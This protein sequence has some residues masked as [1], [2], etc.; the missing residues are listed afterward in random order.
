MSPQ[1]A[2][3]G[4]WDTPITAD[5]ITGNST[6]L[7]DIVVDPIT[8]NIYHLELRPS[9][10]GRTV[11]VDTRAKRDIFGPEWNAADGVHEYGGGAA[12]VY[13]GIAYFSNFKDGRIY[14]VSVKDDGAAPEAVTPDNLPY[15]Y[16]NFAIHPKYT[17]LIVAILEDHTH[18]IPSEVV[19]TLCLIDTNTKT[20]SPKFV[21]GN[22]F[23]SHPVFSTDGNYLAWQEWSFPDMPWEGGEL[24]VA[25]VQVDGGKLTLKSEAK[26]AGEKE[27]YSAGYPLWA[28]SETLIFISD[29]SGFSNPW[30]YTVSDGKASPILPRTVEEDFSNCMWSLSMFPFAVIAGGKQ[31]I[32]SS[33]KDGKNFL[34]LIDIDSGSRSDVPG[35]YVLIDSVRAVGENGIAFIGSAPN[36]GD[37]VVLYTTD[38]D[39]NVLKPNPNSDKFDPSIVSVAQGITLPGPLYVV[40]YPPHNPGYQGL[41]GEKPPCI[42]SVHGGPTGMAY[43]GLSWTIQYYTSRGFAW[44]DVNYGG[45]FGYGSEYRNRLNGEWGIVDVEDC[46][47]AVQAMSQGDEIDPQRVV[48]RGGSAGGFTTLLSLCH[49]SNPKTYAGGTSLYGISNLLKLTEDTH[50]FESQY[51]FKLVGGTP[52]QVPKNY[53]DRSAINHIDDFNRPLLLLQGTEDRVVPPEQSQAIYD[54]IKARGGD[55]E[56]KLYPGEGH[57]FKQKEHQIDALE[58]ELAFYTRILNLKKRPY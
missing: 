31:G 54:G 2:P 56:L 27:T 37:S 5:A 15:R 16:A 7:I 53:K 38:G 47:L 41:V 44:M 33:W 46:I 36:K 43:Q 52:E 18:D 34:N 39:Y 29:I 6:S 40:Y 17:N 57:G 19:N 30:K 51:A 45:S 8:S 11:L 14:R 35:P 26:V 20:V 50:K 9:E 12:T 1:I 4:T 3:Y 25:K 55:V 24:Y 13:D 42:V 48:I 49:S 28:S 10:D 23:Y 21:S 32:F 22:D 58:R